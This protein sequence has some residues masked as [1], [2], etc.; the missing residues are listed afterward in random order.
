MKYLLSI[1]CLFVLSCTSAVH[2]TTSEKGAHLKNYNNITINLLN[3]SGTVSISGVAHFSNSLAMAH[4]TKYDGSTQDVMAYESLQFELMNIG[5]N[6]ISDTTKIDAIVDFSIG[7]IRFDPIAGWIAD[8]G[9]V[10]FT[11]YKTGEILAIVRAEVKFVTPTV[12]NIIANL[13]KSIQ[14]IY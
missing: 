10:K 6:I 9:N 7:Q 13:S 2:L 5:F 8:Q 12:K 11:D 14:S 4:G 1:L 3:S